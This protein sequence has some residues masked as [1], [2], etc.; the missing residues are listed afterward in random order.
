MYG[1][2]VQACL[3]GVMVVMFAG[4][5]LSRRL[6]NRS[7]GNISLHSALGVQKFMAHSLVGALL[8]YT[9]SQITITQSRSKLA[10]ELWALWIGD[11]H[12]V[13]SCHNVCSRTWHLW[14]INITYNTFSLHPPLSERTSDKG[15]LCLIICTQDFA[16]IILLLKKARASSIESQRSPFKAVSLYKLRLPASLQPLNTFKASGTLK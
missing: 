2:L 5:S 12:D 10:E 13:E 16:D 3:Y 14:V 4:W 11:I 8:S 6:D 7:P 1:L 15:L 9:C